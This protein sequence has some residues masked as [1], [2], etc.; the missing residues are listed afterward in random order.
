MHPSLIERLKLLTVKSQLIIFA[1]IGSYVRL[2]DWDK[3]HYRRAAP[4]G[5]LTY[6]SI[7]TFSTSLKP[8]VVIDIAIQQWCDLKNLWSIICPLYWPYDDGNSIM[9]YPN[10]EL[11][12]VMLT[13]FMVF[14]YPFFVYQSSL[15]AGIL[16]NVRFFNSSEYGWSSGILNLYELHISWFIWL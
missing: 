6:F 2:G 5:T 11:H 12:C 4:S 14:Y 8:I 15:F 16:F 13:W 3:V 7:S 1:E 10:R 9:I